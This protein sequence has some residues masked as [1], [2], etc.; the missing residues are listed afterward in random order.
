MQRRRACGCGAAFGKVHTHSH[1]S[2]GLFC[3]VRLSTIPGSSPVFF[4][5]S[6]TMLALRTSSSAAA[7]PR[8]ALPRSTASRGRTQKPALRAAPDVDP[9]TASTTSVAGLASARRGTLMA[10][11]S[12]VVE[13]QA[14]PPKTHA[15]P[16]VILQ[17]MRIHGCNATVIYGK[18]RHGVA[19]M[20][21]L[22]MAMEAEARGVVVAHWGPQRRRVHSLWHRQHGMSFAR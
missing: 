11:I 21:R 17:H 22:S 8:V 15:R 2:N 19:R 3:H 1:Q 5:S 14:R 16:A 10:R 18:W 6:C 12:E 7:G 4:N 9:T 13:H 20:G